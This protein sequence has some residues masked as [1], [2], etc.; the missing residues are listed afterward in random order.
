VTLIANLQETLTGLG[1]DALLVTDPAN[2]RYLS[3]FRSPEDGRVLV[4][5]DGALLITDGRYT[6]QAEEES[7]LEVVITREWLEL[8]VNR[9]GK[10]H[11]AVES[12]H[13]TLDTFT[14]LGEKLAY[15]AIATKELLASHRRIKSGDELAKL[16]RASRI[17]DE[18]F[19]HILG[20]LKAGVTE[21]EVAMEL[22]R[23]MRLAGSE[24]NGFSIIVASGNRSAMPHGI[25]SSKVIEEGDLVTLD[26]GAVVDGYHADMTRAVAVG[27][28]SSKLRF[29][30]DAVLEAQES[31]LAALGPGVQARA[32]DEMAR[33]SLARHN[34][35]HYFTHG[36]GHGV[37]LEIHEAPHLSATSSELLGAGMT[38]TVEPGVYIPGEGGVRIEDLTVITESGYQLLSRS[39]KRLKSV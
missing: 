21:L 31:A 5:P 25:A 24:G 20:F 19:E 30:F 34:L 29:M 28:I 10:A 1:A 11:L 32:V 18:A 27:E 22:E 39:P 26:F 3:G 16:R 38:A 17:T 23:F 13:I 33:E 12:E 7:R 8:V 2:V 37:G 36:L 9:V 4:S 6:V 14:T 15:P 35:E